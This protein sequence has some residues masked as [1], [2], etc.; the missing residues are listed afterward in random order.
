MNLFMKNREECDLCESS[1]NP[2]DNK[3]E[4]Q[5]VSDLANIR[6]SYFCGKASF[7]IRNFRKIKKS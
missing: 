4:A 3:I 6:N 2:R 5:C 1:F 7:L